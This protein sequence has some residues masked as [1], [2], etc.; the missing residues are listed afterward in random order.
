MRRQFHSLADKLKG[1][2]H[3]PPRP[4]LPHIIH[5]W[6]GSALALGL[7]AWLTETTHT[8]LLMGSFGASCVLVFGFPRFPLSQPRNVIGGHLLASFVGLLFLK[9]LGPSWWNL[10]LALAT[11]TALM[12]YTR[13]AHPPG[14]ANVLIIM[15][16]QPDWNFLF[17]P[18][19]VGALILIL[20]A[21]VINNLGRDRR[22]PAYWLG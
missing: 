8:L 3:A 13:T 20:I 11:L 16:T 18:T 21:L 10:A 9:L 7:L 19:L 15:A 14:G 1:G 4:A 2:D 17:T 6:L 5:A 22:Y 12:L